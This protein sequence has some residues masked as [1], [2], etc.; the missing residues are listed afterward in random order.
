MTTLPNAPA[1]ETCQTMADVRAGVDAVDRELVKLIARRQG[2]MEAA[3]R[4][5]PDRDSVRD[6]ARIEQVLSN[7]QEL[8]W[9]I[10]LSWLIAEPVWRTLI[11][12]CIA[13]ELE[14]FD[15]RANDLFS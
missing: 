10:G 4:I 15:Q 8:S 11:E 3:A 1:P 12:R 6:E 13:H 5:K 14:V 9:E 2:Y 7:V